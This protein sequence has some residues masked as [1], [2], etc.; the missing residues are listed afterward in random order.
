MRIAE[1]GEYAVL[2]LLVEQPRHG[3]ALSRQFAPGTDLR[4]VVRLEMSQLYAILKKLETLGLIAT[5]DGSASDE[6]GAPT[7]GADAS[8]LA[9]EVAHDAAGG[10]ARTRRV[11]QPT[12]AG[13]AAFEA[14]LAEPVDRPRDLRLMFLLKLFFALRRTPAD[15][16]A[17]LER[18]EGSF[19]AFH[20]TLTRQ[21]ADPS[22]ANASGRTG[23]YGTLVLRSRLRQTE[24]A[25]AWLGD[26]RAALAARGG[27]NMH[28]PAPR[29]IT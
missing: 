2:G 19:A 13:R 23:L 14:W 24:A 16:A 9:H 25:Q 10:S 4:Q 7:P 26:V 17:L 12:A 20:N 22:A 11:Y 18:Q 3:Y 6:T 15:V 29:Q 1:P 21:L 8:S 28:P 5:Q 27:P